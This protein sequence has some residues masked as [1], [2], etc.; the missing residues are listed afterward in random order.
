MTQRRLAAGIAAILFSLPIPAM[1]ANF[2]IDNPAEKINNPADKIKNPADKIYNPASQIKNPA[3]N[4]YNPASRM[5]NPSPISPP[6]QPVPQPTVAKEITKKIPAGQIKKRP[7]RQTRLAIPQKS[8]NLK[9]VGAYVI[10]AKKAFIRD[11]YPEFL[12]ITEDA[13]RRISAGTLTASKKAKQK[14]VKYKV[15]GYGLLENDKE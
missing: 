3:S 11:N 14:L 9:T 5:D 1:S 2:T 12:S 6:T 15:F 7:L 8:Y 13:L 10:A 4:I